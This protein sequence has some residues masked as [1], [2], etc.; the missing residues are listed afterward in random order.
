MGR[1]A[2]TSRI[3][4][5]K[6]KANPV[7]RALIKDKFGGARNIRNERGG[8]EMVTTDE[9]GPGRCV[10]GILVSPSLPCVSF[11]FPSN[12][13]NHLRT[14]WFFLYIISPAAVL[15]PTLVVSEQRRCI[16]FFLKI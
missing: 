15:P 11:S 9:G 16:F 3:R 10:F 5:A 7:G 1:N 8:Y 14:C 4:K 2:G 6:S 12:Q 13:S